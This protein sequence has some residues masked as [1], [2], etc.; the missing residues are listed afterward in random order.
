MPAA[1]NFLSYQFSDNRLFRE[2]DDDCVQYRWR[3]VQISFY[4]ILFRDLRSMNTLRL[5]AS[6]FIRTDGILQIKSI[7]IFIQFR[8]IYQYHYFSCLFTNSNNIYIRGFFFF[9]YLVKK[10]IYTQ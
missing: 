8:K 4:G 7:S 9:F 10:I 3:F 1:A 6:L 5:N 2:E